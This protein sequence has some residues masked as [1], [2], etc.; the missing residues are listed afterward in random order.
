[1]HRS[2][3]LSASNSCFVACPG[4]YNYFGTTILDTS[5]VVGFVDQLRERFG[6]R[7]ITIGGGDPLTRHD[8]TD[9]LVKI[10]GLGLSIHL[11]TVGTAFLGGAPIRFMGRGI[12]HSV[13]PAAVAA[14]VDLVGIPLDGSTDSINQRFRRFSSLIQ[15]QA[16]LDRLDA[17]GAAVCVN[18]VVHAGNVGDV[19]NIALL[20]AAHPC[21]REWQLFQFMP[22]GPLGHRN[23]TRFELSASTYD[24]AVR[25]LRRVVPPRVRVT[26]KSSASRKNRYLLVD[27]AGLVWFPCQEGSAHWQQYD[28]NGDRTVLGQIPDSTLLDRIAELNAADSVAERIR[29]DAR[30][31][32][33]SV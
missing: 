4:C 5:S 10:H 20:L 14:V 15:Q 19:N 29:A 3:I 16:I 28:T 22:M 18:T 17:L 8:I 1:M 11:D 7:K 21:V 27:S 2:V 32:S 33:P 30:C 12:A 25:N 23:R 9:L 13:D 6:L 31:C 26:A 24:R